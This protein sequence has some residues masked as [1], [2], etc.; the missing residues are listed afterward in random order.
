[1]TLNKDALFIMAFVVIAL[2]FMSYR[3]GTMNWDL[4]QANFPCH[5][6]ELLGYG[7]DT[8]KV[9]C[10]HVDTF[11]GRNKQMKVDFAKHNIRVL[12]GKD[13]FCAIQLTKSS[14]SVWEKRSFDAWGI[15]KRI[16]LFGWVLYVRYNFHS[17]NKVDAD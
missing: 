5:E 2:V 7:W 3:M 10:I 9:V 12:Y 1:M 13:D 6:D 15:Y 14:K 8:H 17:A 16:Y 11:N 4:S